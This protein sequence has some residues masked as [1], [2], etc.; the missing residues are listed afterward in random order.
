MCMCSRQATNAKSGWM[1][2]TIAFNN[3]FRSGEITEIR[4]IVMERRSEIINR[5]LEFTV[6]TR[7][8]VT[9]RMQSPPIICEVLVND[10]MLGFRLEDGRFI[11]A[12]IGFYPPLAL[13]TSQER[14]H[15]ENQRIICLLA[16]SGCGHWL[17]RTAC[18]SARTRCLCASSCR[19]RTDAVGSPSRLGPCRKGPLPRYRKQP[20]AAPISPS[21]KKSRTVWDAIRCF[22]FFLLAHRRGNA[23]S[24]FSCANMLPVAKNALKKAAS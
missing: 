7:T 17:R 12:P 3:G 5:W 9:H 21:Q 20:K 11:S 2:F 18:R 16:R 24:T 6:A 4:K 13:A 8:R 23:T 22:V 1:T 10:E 19:A 15:L 14:N